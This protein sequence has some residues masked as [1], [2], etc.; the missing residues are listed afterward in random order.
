MAQGL[1]SS[2]ST[3]SDLVT[4]LRQHD[5]AAWSRMADLYGPLVF[6]WCRRSQLQ[7]ADAADV[8][9]NVFTAVAGAIAGY[10]RRADGNFRGWLWTITRNKINDHFRQRGSDSLVN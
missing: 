10:E 3:S 8:V 7:Q 6:Y 1:S 4:R 5:A 9:Q 2:E